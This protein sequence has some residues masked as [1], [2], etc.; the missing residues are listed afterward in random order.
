MQ[1]VKKLF[2]RTALATAPRTESLSVK[3]ASESCAWAA[4]R[5]QPSPRAST[6]T[7][8]RRIG[9][10]PPQY[11]NRRI[12]TFIKRPTQIIDVSTLEPP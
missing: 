2:L 3:N 12:D 6:E 7:R 9:I 8:R 1:T 11:E 10:G 4:P 5:K